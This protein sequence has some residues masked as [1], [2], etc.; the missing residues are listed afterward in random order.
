VALGTR[1][2]EITDDC[3]GC[4][5]A[6]ATVNGTADFENVYE[7]DKINRSEYIIQQSAGANPVAPKRAEF[8]YDDASRPLNVVTYADVAPVSMVNLT[9]WRAPQNLIHVL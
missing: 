8:M 5:K 4:R 7:Y 1:K 3:R 2:R 6:R 9:C